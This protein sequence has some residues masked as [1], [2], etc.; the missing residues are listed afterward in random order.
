MRHICL[1]VVFGLIF[2]TSAYASKECKST[3]LTPFSLG[4]K[5]GSQGSVVKRTSHGRFEFK[6]E[7]TG[8]SAVRMRFKL[9]GREMANTPFEL[10]RPEAKACFSEKLQQVGHKKGHFHCYVLGEP[11]CDKTPHGYCYAMACCDLPGGGSVCD[12]GQAPF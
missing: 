12:G 6:A 2:S 5:V 4:A 9:G 11:W 7:R 3:T 1:A 10:M 8:D